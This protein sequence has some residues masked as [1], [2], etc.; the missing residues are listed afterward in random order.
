VRVTTTTKKQLTDRVALETQQKRGTV[1]RIIQVL[2]DAMIEEMANGRRIEFRD[3]GVFE[4]K[5]RA[6]RLAQNPKTLEPVQI[7][8]RRTVK[9]KVGRVM[10]E[11][12][13]RADPGTSGNGASTAS[14]PGGG[15]DRR[16]LASRNGHGLTVEV[17]PKPRGRPAGKGPVRGGRNGVVSKP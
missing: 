16:N 9:F 14:G 2:L 17:K 10:R 6:P 8:A 5:E 11:R 15:G 1:K 3:F 4:I 7:P 13:D 12:M